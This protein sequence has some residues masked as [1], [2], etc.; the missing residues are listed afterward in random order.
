MKLTE[1]NFSTVILPDQFRKKK[2]KKPI[3]RISELLESF[4]D[5]LVNLQQ[6]DVLNFIF[7][8]TEAKN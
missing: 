5:K 1:L 7:V 6:C 3:F 2:K 8:R 4:I